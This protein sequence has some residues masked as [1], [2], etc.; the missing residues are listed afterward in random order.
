MPPGCP[1]AVATHYSPSLRVSK[2]VPYRQR[3]PTTFSPLL[4]ECVAWASWSGKNWLGAGLGRCLRMSATNQHVDVR[5]DVRLALLKKF[6]ED[7]DITYRDYKKFK[8][9]TKI[10]GIGEVPK[11]K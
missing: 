5:V 6:N 10:V 4:A 2:A 8:T 9:D 7:V 3:V 11:R 1:L